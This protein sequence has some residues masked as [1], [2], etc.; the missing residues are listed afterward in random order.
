MLR[1][2][3]EIPTAVF[4]LSL[5]IVGL[6]SCNKIRQSELTATQ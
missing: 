5:A 6:H 2:A 4:T 3:E 1:D